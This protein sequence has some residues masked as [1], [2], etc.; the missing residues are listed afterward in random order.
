[1]RFPVALPTF[2]DVHPDYR[3][4]RWKMLQAV[5]QIANFLFKRITVGHGFKFHRITR[6][7]TAASA[8]VPPP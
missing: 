5:E 6:P 8:D 1:M 7:D 2:D 4:R 3:S